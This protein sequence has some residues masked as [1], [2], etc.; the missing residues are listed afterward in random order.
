MLAPTVV[1]GQRLTGIFDFRTVGTTEFLT[2]FYSAR[3]AVFDAATA[4]DAVIFVNV[5]NIGGTR[6]IRS[7]EKLRSTERV[8]D[9]YIAVADCENLAL[10][11][12]IRYLMNKSVVLGAF[13][14]LHRFFVCNVSALARLTAIISHVAD[15]D[16]P[17]FGVVR[18][19]LVKQ[20]SA[21][22]A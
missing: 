16:T 21:V 22:T 7:I 4:S 1:V 19:A 3:G 11:V 20:F 17:K 8:T 5:R 18:T 2:E 13:K 10:A 12:D 9:I 14:Y 6:H 15:T